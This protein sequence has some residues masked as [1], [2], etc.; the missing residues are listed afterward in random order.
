MALFFHSVHL[1]MAS[2]SLYGTY[3]S[4]WW[5]GRHNN[6]QG[7]A[8]AKTWPASWTIPGVSRPMTGTCKALAAPVYDAGALG[9]CDWPFRYILASD[10]L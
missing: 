5:P 1:Y 10:I 9:A 8:K 6:N 2:S 3:G 4:A 7:T